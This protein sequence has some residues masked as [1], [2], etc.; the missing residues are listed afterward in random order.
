MFDI[1][2]LYED[3]SVEALQIIEVQ[4]APPGWRTNQRHF[5][6]FQTEDD[7]NPQWCSEPTPAK[8]HRFRVW[9]EA[10]NL[11]PHKLNRQDLLS[12][13]NESVAELFPR[14]PSLFGEAVFGRLPE[15]FTI[16]EFGEALP[17]APKSVNSAEDT[18]PT[19]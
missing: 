2:E 10:D 15:S 4:S 19:V 12:L 5:L 3:P 6:M 14:R 7:S 17:A 1:D 13:I 16:V 18:K 11:R 8:G 9:A